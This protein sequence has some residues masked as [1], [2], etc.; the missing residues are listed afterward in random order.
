MLNI[1]E[2]SSVGAR[3]AADASASQT[4]WFVMKLSKISKKLEK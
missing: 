4:L 2:H 3:C 1:H